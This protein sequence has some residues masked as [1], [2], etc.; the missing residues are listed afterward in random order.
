[1]TW[2]ERIGSTVALA[3]ILACLAAFG[4]ACGVLLVAYLG[5]PLP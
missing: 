1:M 4:A 2:L 3:A 5:A